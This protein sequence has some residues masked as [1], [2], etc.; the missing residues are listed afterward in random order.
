MVRKKTAAAPEAAAEPA[1]APAAMPEARGT[2]VTLGRKDLLEQV[3]VA[4]GARKKDVKSVVDATLSLMGEALWRGEVLQ[5]P[6]FGVARVTRGAGGDKSLVVR[7]RRGKG[8]KP[9][10]AAKDTLAEAD[11]AD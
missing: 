7:L 1:P 8:G 2:P 5:L 4:S 6:P 11:E 9:G 3:R 10:A